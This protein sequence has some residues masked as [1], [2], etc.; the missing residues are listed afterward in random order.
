MIKTLREKQLALNTK[1]K[2]SIEVKHDVS[3]AV[4][5]ELVDIIIKEET[6]SYQFIK[7]TVQMVTQQFFER[8]DIVK[9]VVITSLHDYSTSI[10]ITNCMLL[11]FGYS[12]YNLLSEK[13]TINLALVCLLHDI[14]KIEVPDYLLQAQRKL[15]V[16]EFKQIKEHPRHSFDELNNDH[17]D[18]IVAQASLEHHE[19]LDG[20]GYPN[21]ITDISNIAKILTIIDIFEALTNWR[22]YKEII[23]PLNALA[24][25][26]REEVDTGKIDSKIFA[27]FANSLVTK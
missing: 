2:K 22:P 23:T 24:I 26:K 10:H 15:T 7:D 18:P 1:L 19:K 12:V 4:L 8:K 20:S 14:G 13:D 9:H 27:R 11:S 17:F 6:K 25:M 5:M 21:G 16:K 3:R